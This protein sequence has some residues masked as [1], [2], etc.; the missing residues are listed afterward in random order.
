[1]KI[2]ES[3]L[4]GLSSVFSRQFSRPFG[5]HNTDKS[6]VYTKAGANIHIHACMSTP[7]LL[8]QAT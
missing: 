1:M 5:S 8:T 3:F 2:S 7:T 6:Q 4:V